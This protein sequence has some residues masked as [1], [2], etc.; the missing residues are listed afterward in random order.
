MGTSV[1]AVST[2]FVSVSYLNLIQ[3][4]RESRDKAMV[5]F[6]EGLEDRTPEIRSGACA[7]LA[8]L[9]VGWPDSPD[10][11]LICMSLWLA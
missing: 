5:T 10:Y 2:L 4:K 6:V 1:P 8:I 7:A 9:E 3:R 11:L